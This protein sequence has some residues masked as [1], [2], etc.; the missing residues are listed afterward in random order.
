MVDQPRKKTNQPQKR[1]I[2]KIKA[3]ATKQKYV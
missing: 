3:A 2:S 1:W